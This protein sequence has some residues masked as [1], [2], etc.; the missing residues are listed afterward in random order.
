MAISERK[1]SAFFLTTDHWLMLYNSTT[2]ELTGWPIN[3]L[4]NCAKRGVR[5][6]VR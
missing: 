5:S 4:A 1:G 2:S 6:V 3:R